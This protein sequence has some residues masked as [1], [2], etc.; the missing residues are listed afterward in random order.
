MKNSILALFLL[1][2]S[3]SSFAALLPAPV[4]IRNGRAE[5]EVLPPMGLLNCKECQNPYMGGVK[6]SSYRDA[7][8]LREHES[9]IFGGT[10]DAN[11]GKGKPVK[12]N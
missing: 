2:F 9:I 3:T 8:L 5:L 11:G 10:S 4:D 7:A 1:V 6:G 12:E